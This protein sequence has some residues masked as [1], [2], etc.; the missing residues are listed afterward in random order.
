[1]TKRAS[2]RK[3]GVDARARRRGRHRARRSAKRALL[4]RSTRGV[5]TDIPVKHQHRGKARKFIRAVECP[6]NLNLSSH[7]DDTVGLILTIRALCKAGLRVPAYIDFKAIRTI[8]PAAALLL[9]AELD[10]W[11]Q[12]NRQ[13]KLKAV[14][15]HLW[16]ENVRKLLKQM[17]FFEL[18]GVDESKIKCKIPEPDPSSIRFLPFYV[19][20][21]AGGAEAEKLRDLIEKFAGRLRDR[22]ALYDGLVE[23]M[24]NV[25]HHAYPESKEMKRWWISASVDAGNSRLTVLCLDHGVGIPKTLPRKN[26]EAVRKYLAGFGSIVEDVVKDDAKMIQAATQLKRSSTERRNRGYGLQRDIRRYVA[27]HNSKGRLRIFSN[28]GMYCF[29]KE[30]SGQELTSLK[31]S[32]RSIGGTFIEW[33]VE[34][35]AMEPA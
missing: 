27:S 22:Y 15:V 34:D 31:N 16:D 29:E 9:A 20:E 23:A 19:G 1:M 5:V 18:L 17:G 25:H 4:R 28:S 26:A 13:R 12:V 14:D 32:S 3:R 30:R 10:R 6:E 21:G 11:N 8:T 7:Y 24:T 2:A 33:V 35:Y